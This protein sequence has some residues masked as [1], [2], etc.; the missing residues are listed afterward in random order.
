MRSTSL[1]EQEL[2]VLRYI[3][4]HAP[5]SVRDVAAHFAETRAL[6]RTTVL[7]VMERLRKKG[8]LDRA[9]ADGTNL[10]SPRREQ[11]AVL[12][13]LVKDFAERVLGGSFD[14]FIAYLATDAT[15]THQQIDDL[16]NVVAQLEQKERGAHES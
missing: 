14:P 5:V 3:S 7:T 16:R 2:H 12:R 13:D 9:K 11:R 15:L 10:Y 8:F 6:A 1:G 4:E